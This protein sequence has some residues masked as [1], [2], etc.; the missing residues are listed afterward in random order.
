MGIHGLL[1]FLKAYAQRA[2]IREFRGQT[3]GVDAMCWMHKGAFS[4]AQELVE[5]TDTDMFIHFFLRMCEVLRSNDIKPVIVFDGARLPAKAKEEAHRGATRDSARLEALD[6]IERRRRGEQVDDRLIATKCE[7]AIRIRGPMITRLMTALR[8]FS[9]Q[10]I[11]APFEADAQLAYMCRQGWLHA[12]I[13]EDSDLL[14][15]GCPNTFYKMDKHGDGQRYTLPWLQPRSLADAPPQDE[16]EEDVDSAGGGEDGDHQAQGAE[17]RGGRGRGARGR[18][19]GRGR[20]G[21]RPVRRRGEL[22]DEGAETVED[23][24]APNADNASAEVPTAA[25][26]AAVAAPPED[27][28]ALLNKWTTEK[29]VEFCVLLGTDYK[30]DNLKIK[31][32]GPHNAFK[33]LCRFKGATAMIKWM[34]R[35]K[36]WRDKLPCDVDEY[37]Q[38]L[39]R[40]VAVFWHH[41]VFDPQRGACVSIAIAFPH[42]DRDIPGIDIPA[43][44]GTHVE[45]AAAIASG[46]VDPRTHERRPQA[47]L[48]AAERNLMDRMLAQKRSD[49]RQG[50]FEHKLRE[51]AQR[52]AAQKEHEAA[53]QQ[54]LRE[55][56]Q[57]IS[58]ARAAA[59]AASAA[60]PE[61]AV[62]EPAGQDV[63]GEEDEDDAKP[64]DVV[65]LP[66]DVGA[67]F[68]AKLL[69]GDPQRGGGALKTPPRGSGADAASVTSPPLLPNPFA[70]KR[71]SVSGIAE[72]A[73]VLAKRQRWQEPSHASTPATPTQASTAVKPANFFGRGGKPE[74]FGSI[75]S[76]GTRRLKEIELHPRGGYAAS[77]AVSAVLAQRGTPE[78][79]A[80]DPMKDRSKLTSFF[81]SKPN[82][83]AARRQ[84]V[85]PEAPKGSA[86]KTWNPRPWEEPE[87]ENQ[88]PVS[89]QKDN[90]L[91]S[92]KRFRTPYYE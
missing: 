13:T 90:M 42:A 23:P 71:A 30:E 45:D 21:S 77:D 64:R 92:L 12:V 20:A 28:Q 62:G 80:L 14:A 82:A 78:L 33:L 65:L 66:S 36:K 37:L 41:T 58:A 5:E 69:L 17:G 68:A 26:E 63:A 72:G 46:D 29:F 53:F 49:M 59:S 6:L 31:G 38:R 4:C 48:T 43:L 25:P 24:E 74:H 16:G 76:Q 1:P 87:V 81:A 84:P 22:R 8:E 73:N 54:T 57:R 85:A 52:I 3:I 40:V 51:D 91:F 34:Y 19:Q 83:G 11:V 39:Q 86:L 75:A 15:Y 7:T 32:L 61:G 44:C 55:D 10:F 50:N 88:K 27:G 70:R 9:I 56:G 89:N 67:I 79:E 18:R 47:P 60:Q 35:E 2:N